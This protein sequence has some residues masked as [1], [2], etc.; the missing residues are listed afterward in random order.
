MS[1]LVALD[2]DQDDRIV[3]AIESTWADGDAVCVLDRRLSPSARGQ[4]LATLRPTVLWDESGRSRLADGEPVMDGDALCVTT[5]GSMSDPKAAI[6]TREAVEASARASTT[7]LGIDPGS[8]RWLCCLPVSHIGGLSVLTRAL[9]TGPD[10]EVIPRAD[11]G[12]LR[13][14]ADRGAT[15]VSLVATALQRI[16]PGWFDVILLGGAAPPSDLP[17]NVVTTYGMTETGSGVVYDGVP[18]P[19]VLLGIDGPDAT[20]LG[21]ILIKAPMLLRSFRDRPAHLVRGP[22]EQGGW[23]STGDLGRLDVDGR[24][25]V[26]GRQA[27]VIVTGA[28]KVF[29]QDV[30]AVIADLDGVAEVAVWRRADPEWGER[31]VAWIVPRG[32]APS[33]ETVRDAV[34][35]RLAP[36]AAPKE[37]EVVASLPRTS[38]GK[39]RRTALR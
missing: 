1:E 33:I 19:G 2:L 17:D 38:S 25:S 10:L 23:L 22:D 7:A 36:Y 13:A 16:D 11:P 8:A 18:L 32:E 9:V 29:P 21:E 20:G 26:R 12:A 6:L 31:V 5:S 14:A 35:D 28:E 27:E 37:I 34:A 15:H 39:L 24:L 4:S 30:E 3:R